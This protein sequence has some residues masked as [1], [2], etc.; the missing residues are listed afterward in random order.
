M[1]G[2]GLREEGWGKVK[3]MEGGIVREEEVGGAG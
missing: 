3:G 1:G 2:A